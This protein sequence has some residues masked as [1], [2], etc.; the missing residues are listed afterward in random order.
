MVTLLLKF[1]LRRGLFEGK[2][3]KLLK[4]K[5]FSKNTPLLSCC[6]E[7]LKDVL[8]FKLR[9]ILTQ[10][11]VFT[12]ECVFSFTRIRPL[13]SQNEGILNLFACS[14]HLALH[15]ACRFLTEIE[16]RGF[17]GI[18]FLKTILNLET[19]I[20]KLKTNQTIYNVETF[21]DSLVLNKSSER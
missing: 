21:E 19:A 16:N 17:S 10:D 6:V 15:H 5:A 12:R 4:F 7:C 20:D 13:S 11:V 9:Q 2:L 8:Y 1:G 14:W 18:C 3:G